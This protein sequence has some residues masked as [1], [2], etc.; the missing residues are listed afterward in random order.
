MV[1]VFLTIWVV[2][3]LKQ[4]SAEVVTG[5][6]VVSKEIKSIDGTVVA[7][8]DGA[9]SNGVNSVKLNP[10]KTPENKQAWQSYYQ[11]WHPDEALVW[12]ENRCPDSQELGMSCLRRQGNLNQ[13]ERLNTPV[14]LELSSNALLLVQSVNGAGWQVM[15]ENG[16]QVV[17]KSV[18]EEQ[19]FGTYFVLWPLAQELIGDTMSEDVALWVKSMAM[20]I[21]NRSMT[22]KQS[23]NWVVEFQQKNGLLADGIVGKETQ[24]AMALQAYQGPKLNQAK[25]EQIIKE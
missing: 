21:E 17:K 16:L 3:L 23:Q 13:V 5:S 7:V 6:S 1:L 24:M 12:Q 10:I 20:V 14:L 11:L 15:T 25:V 2:P 8:S 19:W 22:L 18:I 4:N 9:D